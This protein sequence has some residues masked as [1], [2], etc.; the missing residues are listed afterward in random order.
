MIVLPLLL[1]LAPVTAAADSD[2]VCNSTAVYTVYNNRTNECDTLTIAVECFKDEHC[3]STFKCN[4]GV[5]M[6]TC[7][8]ETLQM[9]SSNGTKL[10]VGSDGC[11]D[12]CLEYDERCAFD[13]WGLPAGCI[14]PVN[15]LAFEL[16]RTSPLNMIGINNFFMFAMYPNMQSF[17]FNYYLIMLITVKLFYTWMLFF[18]CHAVLCIRTRGVARDQ[19]GEQGGLI[20]LLCFVII[21]LSPEMFIPNFFVDER[22]FPRNSKGD[23]DIGIAIGVT[24]YAVLGVGLLLSGVRVSRCLRSTFNRLGSAARLALPGRRRCTL[25]RPPR[26]AELGTCVICLEDNTMVIRCNGNKGRC[27]VQYHERCLAHWRSLR[28][29]NN[30]CLGCQEVIRFNPL[31]GAIILT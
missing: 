12:V 3:A 20:V 28:S 17:A 2:A 6:C 30:K 26:D 1:L 19:D 18:L 14:A 4:R 15:R 13:K 11:R 9:T 10:C 27:T 8:E 5:N 21:I 23:R 24:W 25:P 29:A 16:L 22:D 31:N 7:P